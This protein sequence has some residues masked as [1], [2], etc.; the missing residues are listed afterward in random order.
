MTMHESQN[1]VDIILVYWGGISKEIISFQI[2][3][4]GQDLFS[5]IWWKSII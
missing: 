5:A 1:F 4:K 2:G 3:G